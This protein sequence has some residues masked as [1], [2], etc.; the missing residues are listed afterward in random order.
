M[1]MLYFNTKTQNINNKS[2]AIVVHTHFI[3]IKSEYM[4]LYF[5]YCVVKNKVN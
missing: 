2:I 1:K 3:L 5:D 4:L